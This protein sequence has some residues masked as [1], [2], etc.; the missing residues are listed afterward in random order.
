[1]QCI[2]KTTFMKATKEKEIENI[3]LE[4]SAKLNDLLANYQIYYQ[5]LR[6]MHWNIRGPKFFELHTK[7]EELYNDALLKVDEIAERIL[8]LGH[9]PLHTF[10]D[11]IKHSEIIERKNIFEAQKCVQLIIN[12]LNILLK[13]EKD[14]LLLSNELNDEG[15]NTILGDYIKEQ[16]KTLWMLNAYLS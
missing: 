5:N 13:K 1:M 14:L 10:S 15:T 11:Y 12:N 4:L 3:K 7:F 6:G 2:I 9:K 16:E 8:T